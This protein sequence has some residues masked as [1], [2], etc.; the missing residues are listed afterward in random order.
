MKLVTFESKHPDPRWGAL[1][2][3]AECMSPSHRIPGDSL[4][5]NPQQS[6]DEPAWAGATPRARPQCPEHPGCCRWLEGNQDPTHSISRETAEGTQPR[7]VS[8]ACPPLSNNLKIRS[9][10]SLSG[11]LGHRSL[12]RKKAN[13]GQLHRNI[14]NN[15]DVF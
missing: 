15:Q 1:G 2:S 6:P 13:P 3:R 8:R 14:N 9:L 10:L 5:A 12:N 7:K 4:P 11:C